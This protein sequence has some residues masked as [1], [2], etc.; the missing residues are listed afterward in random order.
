MVKNTE[1]QERLEEIESKLDTIIDW[2]ESEKLDKELM[3]LF[4]VRGIK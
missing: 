3:E 4:P 2:I 1:I